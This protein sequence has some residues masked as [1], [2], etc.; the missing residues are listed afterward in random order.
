M[1]IRAQSLQLNGD[2]WRRNRRDDWG[3]NRRAEGW[4]EHLHVL[5]V[6]ENLGRGHLTLNRISSGAGHSMAVLSHQN[7][8][9]RMLV[10]LKTRDSNRFYFKTR[11]SVDW[12]LIDFIA[13]IV[14]AVV[15]GIH[16]LYLLLPFALSWGYDLWGGFLR[17]FLIYI[18]LL[19][20]SKFF[21]FFVN[22]NFCFPFNSYNNKTLL[23]LI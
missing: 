9:L 22:S 12:G 5:L 14:V 19:V 21:Y 6:Y 8:C 11:P 4:R 20:Q 16:H 3:R 18:V 1:K 2:Q 23:R 13:V 7:L 17:Q 10:T 15:T